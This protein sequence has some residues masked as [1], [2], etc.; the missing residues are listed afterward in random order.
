MNETNE[1]V[2]VKLAGQDVVLRRR[3]KAQTIREFADYAASLMAAS[4]DVEKLSEVM[5]GGQRFPFDAVVA[6]LKA[7]MET[8]TVD[9]PNVYPSEVDVAFAALDMEEFRRFFAPKAMEAMGQ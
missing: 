5:K 6:V 8:G 7:Q 9:W 1:L 2:T 3:A 4:G